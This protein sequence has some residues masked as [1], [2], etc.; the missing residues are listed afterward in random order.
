MNGLLE[1]VIG[2]SWTTCSIVR[3]H[4]AQ[5]TTGY[6]SRCI[7]AEDHQTWARN[8][9]RENSSQ[10][11]DIST[12]TPSEDIDG[13]EGNKYQPLESLEPKMI[14]IPTQ[15][16]NTPG[17][18]PSKAVPMPTGNQALN[19]KDA[20]TYRRMTGNRGSQV[21]ASRKG[22]MVSLVDAGIAAS[23]LG[24]ILAIAV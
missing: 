10:I 3:R 18:S 23:W 8:S 21:R 12:W 14:N 22:P 2:L 20:G 17:K 19:A 1:L 5:G 16:V 15:W 13:C 24:L 9:N 6:P 7:Y 4:A 11:S